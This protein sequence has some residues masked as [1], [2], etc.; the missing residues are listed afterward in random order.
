[1]RL[2]YDIIGDKRDGRELSADDITRFLTGYLR[3]ELTDYQMSA[4][5]MAVCIRGLT[6]AE[7][8]VW[9][10]TMLHSGK[11]LSFPDDG[12]PVVDKHSTGGVGDKIS[13]PL[14]PLLAALGF[15]V[16]MISGRGLG[17]TGGTLDKLESIPG[18]RVGLDLD[19]FKRQVQELGVAMIGQTAE[20]A[21]LDRRLYALR[22]VTG[23]VESVPLIASSIM[24]KKLAEGIDGLLLD[25]KT[26]DGAFMQEMRDAKKLA[27][28]MKD[29]G[30]RAGKKMVVLITD[31]SEPLGRAAGHALEIEESIAV[32]RGEDIPQVT[33]LTLRQAAELLLAFGKVKN[34]AAGI[35]SARKRLSDGTALEIFRRMVERQGGDPRVLDDPSLLPSASHIH[36]LT[37]DRDGFL[38]GV[39]ARAV[40]KALVALGG[41]R[42]RKEDAIDPAVGMIFPKKVGDAVAKGEPVVRIH[43]RDRARLD[44]ALELLAGAVSVSDGPVT[45][46]KLITGRA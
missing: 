30:E 15:R 31:M 34:R 3:D 10:A 24:S 28:T 26:G 29:I 13:I 32:L 39:G 44:A 18:F 11:V 19:A 25:V 41:G 2:F 33:E 35:K 20:I 42:I 6:P 1:M 22:D 40:G 36:E 9:A 27:A 23:T 43:Y 17:H 4:L 37:A 12:R 16:P 5:L 46:R 7:L 21:P 8:S 38:A 45:A 14:A